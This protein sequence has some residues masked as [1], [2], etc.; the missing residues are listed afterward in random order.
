VLCRPV[1]TIVTPAKVMMVGAA[2]L[3]LMTHGAKVLTVSLIAFAAAPP[4]P[5][6][7]GTMR[8]LPSM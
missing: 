7:P 3:L 4:P 1:L 8:A 5:T 6:A 2:E